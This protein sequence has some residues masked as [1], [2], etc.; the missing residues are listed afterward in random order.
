MSGVSRVRFFGLNVFDVR[1]VEVASFQTPSFDYAIVF[2]VCRF[3]I[4]RFR[5][6]PLMFSI[7]VARVVEFPRV[8]F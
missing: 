5:S 6:H 8:S 1:L 7:L 4:S 3:P 2:Q